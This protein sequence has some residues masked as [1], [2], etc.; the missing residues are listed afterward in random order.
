MVSGK[1][2]GLFCSILMESP[3][4]NPDTNT[5][6][7]PSDMGA[8][9]ASPVPSGDASDRVTV[10]DPPQKKGARFWLIFVALCASTF[11]SALELVCIV[12][13]C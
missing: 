12:Y 3:S 7:P 5:L 6:A 9:P 2:L 13:L 10:V 1:Q 4:I 11:L 8:K